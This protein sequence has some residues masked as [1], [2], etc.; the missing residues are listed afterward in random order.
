MLLAKELTS[1]VEEAKIF[2]CLSGAG[3]GDSSSSQFTPGRL[4]LISKSL[5]IIRPKKS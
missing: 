4:L 2:V 3:M 1:I 5:R